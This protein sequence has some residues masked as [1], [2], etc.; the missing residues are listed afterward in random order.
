MFAETDITVY[1]LDRRVVE[2]P[3]PL[4]LKDKSQSVR[5][6]CCSK[7]SSVIRLTISAPDTGLRVTPVIPPRKSLAVGGVATWTVAS[8]Q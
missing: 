7:C 4:P 2:C 8:P 1:H 5:A 3:T 6:W